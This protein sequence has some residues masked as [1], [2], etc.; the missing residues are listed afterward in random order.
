MY[1]LEADPDLAEGLPPADR[2]V[3]TRLLRAAVVRVESS[4]WEPMPPPDPTRTF[5]L[6]VLDGLVG[7]RAKVGLGVSTELLSR[8]D[9][10][11]PWHGPAAS[12]P[13]SAELTWRVFE[14]IRLAI[15]DARITA[16]IGRRP[17]L[18]V[19][20]SGRLLRRAR[21]TGYLSAI[22]HLTRVEDRLF[23]T[24]WHLANSWGRVTPQG[25]CVPFRLTHE[26]LGEMI[27]AKRPSVSH[28][29]GL[30]RRRG[31]LFRR[32]D[33]CYVLTRSPQGATLVSG[34]G[35]VDGRGA[36]DGVTRPWPRPWPPAR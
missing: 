22:S 24:L 8:G 29:A 3:A 11:R 10:L 2:A 31:E 21:D 28:A 20:F 17:E 33:G 16:I 15:L 12:D 30:L 7:R 23:L 35:A 6:L 25:V 32:D 9:I 27:G 36:S 19:A 18:I 26:V 4:R 14:P 1:I 5:G 34:N 13:V